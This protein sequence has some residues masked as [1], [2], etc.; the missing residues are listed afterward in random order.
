MRR[1]ALIGLI[2][3]GEFAIL[4]AG[5]RMFG[6][7]EAEPAFQ[8]LFMPDDRIGYRLRPGV[9]SRYSTTE[10][11]TQLTINAQG[12]RDDEAIGAK[13][14]QERRV[15][16]LGDSFVFAVQVPLAQTLGERLERA[17]NRAQPSQSWRVINGGVQGYGPV[18]QW[19][20]YRDIVSAFDPDIVV[21]VVSV[22]NDAIEAFDAREKLALGRVPDSTPVDRSQARIRQVVRSSMVL[23]IVR[24]RADQLRARASASTAERPL[25]AYLER[26]PDF[27]EDGLGVA[28]EA[29]GHIATDAERAGAAVMF[30]LMPARFQTHDEDF[31]RVSGIATRSRN[32]IVRNA[33]TERF[34]RALAPLGQPILDLLPVFASLDD[35][36]AHYFVQNA[37]LNARG[38]QVTSDAIFDFLRT[39]GV[40]APL[41]NR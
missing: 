18:E 39:Q 28:A 41:P 22:A 4:E 8:R 26:P 30:V 24:L 17:L 14:P 35:P 36:P 16:I 20:F 40:G 6:R 12:V 13:Q 32:A 23:Q 38:H 2:V 19:H 3:L 29:F 31:R 5:L 9:T 37:H 10:F 34:K 1:A 21:I 7:M 15:V 27:V 33:A 25:A 11:S